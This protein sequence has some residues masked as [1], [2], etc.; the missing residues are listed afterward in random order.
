MKRLNEKATEKKGFVYSME[1]FLERYKVPAWELL[2]VVLLAVPFMGFS[3]YL[4]RILIMIGVYAM[5]GMGLNILTGY[6][7]LVSLGHAGF[8]PLVHIRH[9]C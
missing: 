8:L 9:L 3:S 7:G 1:S 2:T 4:M 5:L 6:T